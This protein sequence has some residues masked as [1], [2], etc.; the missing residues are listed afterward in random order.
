V[1]HETAIRARDRALALC[2]AL[3]LL[4]LADGGR[5]QQLAQRVEL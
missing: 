4:R 1:A 5:A 3:A 2:P